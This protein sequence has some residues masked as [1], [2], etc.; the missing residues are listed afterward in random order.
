MVP[1]T[2]GGRFPTSRAV[3]TGPGAV[4]G[5]SG[6]VKRSGMKLERVDEDG[7]LDDRDPARGGELDRVVVQL[8]AADAERA[9]VARTARR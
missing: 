8:V 5:G 1:V 7:L 2:A 6:T 4:L 9:G 3:N